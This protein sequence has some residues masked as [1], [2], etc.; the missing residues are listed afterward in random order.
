MLRQRSE[1]PERTAALWKGR[2]PC[3]VAQRTLVGML[4]VRI[5]TCGHHGHI[6][7]CD[8]TLRIWLFHVGNPIIS[9]HHRSMQC[10]DPAVFSTV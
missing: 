7:N 3:R 10:F 4:L 9:L 1:F 5:R 6:T 2:A 8:V